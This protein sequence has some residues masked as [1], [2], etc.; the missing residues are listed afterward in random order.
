MRAR[1]DRAGELAQRGNDPGAG[2]HDPG[3][4]DELGD[5]DTQAQRRGRVP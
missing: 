2:P 3:V 1:V 5:G 4:R